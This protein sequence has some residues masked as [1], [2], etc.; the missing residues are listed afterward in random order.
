[1][2]SGC[3]IVV[4]VQEGQAKKIEG[5]PLHPVN[6]G[7][8]CAMGESALQ[9]LYN[10]DRV[11]TPLK[12][13]GERGSGQWEAVSWETAN[14]IAVQRL[15]ALQDA[16]ESDR[17]Y[18]VGRPL[19]GHVHKIIS[20]FMEG[21]GSPHDYR[22]DLLDG[23]VQQT[24]DRLCF[25]VDAPPHY[26]IENTDY[27]LSFGANFLETWRAPVRYSRA[28]GDFRQGENRKKR[29]KFVQCEPRLSLTAANAD[30][31]VPLRPGS[32]GLLALGIARI[33]LDKGWYDPGL[34]NQE[35]KEWRGMLAP[36]QPA[37]VA[38][39]TDVSEAAILQLAKDFSSTRPSL[40]LCGDAPAAREA[41]LFHAVAVNILNLVAGNADR[42]GGIQ[43]FDPFEV[44]GEKQMSWR[45][46]K[47]F[48]GKMASGEVK[49]LILNEANPVFHAPDSLNIEAAL[50]NIPFIVSFSSFIDESSA[51]S[52]LIL[53]LHT[54]L[55]S[56]GDVISEDDGGHRSVGLMQPVVVP[57][58]DSRYLG[59]VLMQWAGALGGEV[60]ER[61][62]W[63]NFEA[64]FKEYWE[65]YFFL[66]GFEDGLGFGVDFKP[67]W[68]GLLQKG[69][70]W[71]EEPSKPKAVQP[72][73]MPRFKTVIDKRSKTEKTGE[74]NFHFLP[75]P[76]IF[77]RDGR[78]ANQPWLQEA[79]DPMTTITWGSWIEIHVSTAE[80]LG[81]REGDVVR[82]QSSEGVIEAPAY[83]TP[84][85][86]FDTLAMPIGQ[87]HTAYGRYAEG[88]GINPLKI[89]APAFEA[90]TGA[91]A[92]A[93]TMVS[94][95]K[96]GKRV[97]L[98]KTEGH[99]RQVDHQ[100]AMSISGAE[101]ARLKGQAPLSPIEALP[102]RKG[103]TLPAFFNQALS[104]Y[105]KPQKNN[106]AGDYRW[107]MVIDLDR[108]TGCGVCNI[109]CH[110]ENNLPI[111]GETGVKN[112]RE[113]N[114]IRVER[115]W[116]K[117]AEA[118]KPPLFLPMLC[119][120]C[121]N[122]PCEPVCPVYA[123]YH[124]PDGLNAQ[125]YNRCVGT[126]YCAN[127]CPYKV[128]AFNYSQPEWPEPLTQ[129]LS[130]DLSV[131]DAGIMEKCTFCVQRIRT[132]KEDAKIE[133]RMVRDGEVQPACVASCPAGAMVFG[134]LLD[135][136]G[137]VAK[138][139]RNSRRYRALEHLNTE[140]AVIY[141]KRIVDA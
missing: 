11:Q 14:Q 97:Q 115:Y 1:C 66:K 9:V 36:F 111:A 79:P 72:P 109:A 35:V 106:Q 102:S 69:G 139:A 81:I 37:K 119:Q 46:L 93:G 47:T 51:L 3:G 23:A 99:A 125:V 49:A 129:Q 113:I 52:D 77:L 21:F 64:F 8:L 10:P 73:D 22:Y 15:K 45:D 107:G 43:F 108:C 96:T 4:K 12:R 90:E 56:F 131:R 94:I 55:E 20:L 110:A 87:G 89:V 42:R 31:W 5:N 68:T 57:L 32:E 27:L 53:P 116:P 126:R 16:G 50:K 138:A 91:L 80:R 128:R 24:A 58:Y 41:G 70:R 67:F 76:S 101:A 134:S 2:P 92:W 28:Y 136:G 85:I 118:Q 59:D 6:R 44:I 74:G 63:D 98:A 83:P 78:G 38:Q 61:F 18:F 135:H 19:K 95:A 105:L 88:R 60:S 39:W 48:A 133:K 122:A 30:L 127:N 7:K 82:L 75:Y 25:G 33:I 121:G 100:M 86:R 26:D 17:L 34:P 132:A 104:K 123:T 40:A 13:V 65:E 29:G 140:S 141:L 117:T 130:P 71:D 112:Q 62:P 120:H 114:W 124:T 137:A 54:P 103:V 84:G